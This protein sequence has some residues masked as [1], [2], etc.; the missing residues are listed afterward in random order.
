M[1][2]I[3]HFVRCFPYHKSSEKR[4]WA[5]PDFFLNAKKGDA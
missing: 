3:L 5:S 2:E 4:I 1:D